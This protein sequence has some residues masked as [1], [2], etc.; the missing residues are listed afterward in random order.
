MKVVPPQ[1]ILTELDPRVGSLGDNIARLPLIS[2]VLP[3]INVTAVKRA[4]RASHQFLLHE[5]RTN[6]CDSVIKNI[7]S[8]TLTFNLNCLHRKLQVIREWEK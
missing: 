2:T 7:N 4:S 5:N 8:L 1:T 3:Q 6:G